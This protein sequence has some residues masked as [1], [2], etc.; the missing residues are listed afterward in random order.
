MTWLNGGANDSGLAGGELLVK[1]N[2]K[3]AGRADGN[4]VLGRVCITSQRELAIPYLGDLTAV[5]RDRRPQS[6]PQS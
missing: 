4:A 2:S 3:G 6:D 1:S 5:F